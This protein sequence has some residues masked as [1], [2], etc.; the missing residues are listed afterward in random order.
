[1]VRKYIK[2]ILIGIDQFC[3]AVLGGDPDE[4]LSSRA[5]KLMK[6]HGIKWPRRFI[7][8]LFGS[9]HCEASEEK[10]EGKDSLLR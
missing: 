6:R 1:M 8:W 2:N 3:N 9:G 10:D 4:T 7:D 5:F